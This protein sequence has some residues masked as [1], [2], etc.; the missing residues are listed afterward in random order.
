MP[1]A[2][3][4]RVF[5]ALGL[6]AA[7]SSPASVSAK[8]DRFLA[9]PAD[10]ESS[11]AFRYAKLESEACLAQL[12]ARGV[13]YERVG[14]TARVE[15]PLRFT[16]PIRGVTFR[17]TARAQG[18]H[19]APATIADCR[20]ALAIDDLAVVLQRHG[21]VAAEYLS[22]YRPPVGRSAFIA[23]GRRH[24]SA[25]AIDLAT[26]KL[27]SG[28][29]YSVRYDFHGRVGAQTC[30]EKAAKPTKD[31]P[32][33]RLWRS[34]ACDL[35]EKRSFNLLLTP[36]YDWGHRDHFHMEVRTGIRWFLIH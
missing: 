18:D 3:R 13:P 33:A 8:G 34:I 1:S 9:E 4:A 11:R 16:G 27:D 36:N 30:G 6:G 5:L 31:T 28:K 32:G 25:L 17:P 20:L 14:P 35:E 26:I 7:L 19:M 10:V 15:T 23:P 2:V 22:M 29:L 12:D 24:P 21:V